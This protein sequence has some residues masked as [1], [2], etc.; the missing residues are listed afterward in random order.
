MI[1]PI[2][3][4]IERARESAR[5]RFVPIRLSPSNSAAIIASNSRIARLSRQG[6]IDAARKVFDEMPERTIVSWNSLISAYFIKWQPQNARNLF[7]RM[8]KRNTASY[9]AMISGYIK[10]GHFADAYAV[11][12]SMPDRNVVSWT[13][14]LRGYIQ[15]GAINEAEALFC[16]MPEKNVISWTVMLGGLIKDG[17]IDDAC[18]LFAQMPEKD[19]VAR[20]SMV[21]GFCQVGRTTEA[22]EIFDNM[23]RRNVIAWT[24]MISGYAHNLQ[25]E[26]A[27]KLFEVMPVKNE[28]TWT[29]MLTG[30]TQAGQIE[31]A[32]DLFYRMEEKPVIA[33]NA[34]IIGLGQC[35]MVTEARDVFDQILEKDDGTWSSMVKVYEQNAFQLEAFDVFRSM[36]LANVPPN[37]PSI[38]SVLAVCAG[39]AVI[40]HGKQVH[41]KMIRTHF[42]SDVFTVSALITVYVKCGD[43]AKAK[44][45]FD[46][47]EKKD[48]GVWNSMI[49]GYAQHGL[50][51]E[52]LQV[53][54]DMCLMGMIPDEITYIG[55]LQACSYSGMVKEGREIFKSMSLNSLVRP[56]AEH[57]ACMVDML[58]RAGQVD[59]AMEL[60]NNMHVEA[61]AVVWGAL[62][63]ACRIH[64]NLEIAEIAAKKLLQLEAWNSGPYILLSNIY[65]SSR[66]W[67]DVAK[68][69]KAMSLRN[70]SKSPGCS[71]L[72]V[73]KIVHMFTGGDL[74]AH[75]EKQIIISLLERLDSLLM[76][77]GYHPDFS[78][79][80]HDVDEEQKRHSL[81]YHSERQAVAFGILKVPKG[82]PIY[83]MKN[84]RICG[85]CHIAIKL[86]S[87]IMEREI[88]L[89]DSNRFHHFK[90]G[91]CSCRDYWNVQRLLDEHR[92]SLGVLNI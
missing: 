64:K 38:I 45:I 7:E 11:F 60:V 40:L 25:L 43:L 29:A 53:F 59:E 57:Y 21:S 65:A 1:A 10:L 63:G 87:K 66:R 62:L 91:S 86:I 17:R 58:G 92:S 42:D 15:A 46:S 6:Q 41:A 49:A 14:M 33:C 88:V 9:N 20:T 27:R 83:I 72:E 48:T 13:S 34:M 36:Q 2:T 67:E 80:L 22:R 71:W 81:R 39:L 56:T 16:R 35:G 28:V 5:M 68:L 12:N 3:S 4:S 61:D 47:F 51:E 89:R 54:N 26:L 32:I 30:Y 69:R 31:E 44:I 50:G 52:T 82:M 85:D 76:E 70:V 8:P 37:Y 90:D 78:Y 55:V 23:P 73:D 75:P 77:S 24:A 84:L 18:Q 79:V 19:V 74:I